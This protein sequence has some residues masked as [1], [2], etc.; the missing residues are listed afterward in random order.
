LITPICYNGSLA[1]LRKGAARLADHLRHE[2]CR[3]GARA[4]EPIMEYAE[5]TMFWKVRHGIISHH[6]RPRLVAVAAR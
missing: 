6:I 5:I 3:Y 4:A 1:T 2:L